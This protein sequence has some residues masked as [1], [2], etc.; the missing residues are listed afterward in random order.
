MPNSSRG[1]R[2]RKYND[3]PDTA[4]ER[5]RIR[6]RSYYLRSR[7]APGQVEDLACNLQQPEMI[8]DNVQPAPFN[9]ATR[10][11]QI[12]DSNAPNCVIETEV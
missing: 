9:E 4:R 5:R 12:G 3:D 2:P 8:D 1:G 11:G 10:D 6:N 7:Q